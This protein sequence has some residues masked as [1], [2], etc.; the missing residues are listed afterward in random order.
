MLVFEA[1]KEKPLNVITLGP[2]LTN[3]INLIITIS[4][5]ILI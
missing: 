3:N 1:S 4:T 2:S 5:H